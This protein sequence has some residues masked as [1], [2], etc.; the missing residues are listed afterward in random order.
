MVDIKFTEYL[1]RWTG[2]AKLHVVQPDSRHVL[3]EQSSVVTLQQWFSSASENN[4]VRVDWKLPLRGWEPDAWA[5]VQSALTLSGFSS[6]GLAWAS[7]YRDLF[8]DSLSESI[9]D[10]YLSA[11]FEGS[12]PSFSRLLDGYNAC[13]HSM[14]AGRHKSAT[15]RARL[16]VFRHGDKLG[17][18][19]VVFHLSAAFLLSV[20]QR[21]AFVIDHGSWG[22][23]LRG[24]LAP[25]SFEWDLDE[26]K[27]ILPDFDLLTAAHVGMDCSQL[28]DD[29]AEVLIFSVRSCMEIHQLAQ[30]PYF[31]K[32]RGFF[33]SR[34]A[35]SIVGLI[36]RLLFQPGALLQYDLSSRREGFAGK[37]LVG[38]AIRNGGFSVAD[39]MRLT[40]EDDEELIDVFSSC[41]GVLLQRASQQGKEAVVFVL[42]DSSD[43]MDRLRDKLGS[44]VHTPKHVPVHS[45]GDFSK[46]TEFHQTLL[47][48]FTLGEA[49]DAVI[50]HH[51]S[52]HV[53][54]Y[55]RTGRTAVSI[56]TLQ[57]MNWTLGI[58]P[59]SLAVRRAQLSDGRAKAL[60]L[61]AR[62]DICERREFYT[63]NW[64][65][66]PKKMNLI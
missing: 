14:I 40:W 23:D 13:H 19:N 21:R 25:P 36:S 34:S 43:T 11:T 16:L 46:S 39:V 35:A 47:D 56:N 54:A 53:T 32:L 37:E 57:F 15:Q 41:A 51:S 30:E 44:S 42:S 4:D 65:T 22:N 64:E 50:T 24:H 5:K 63:L 20:L 55:A 58:T 7:D 1:N 6:S 28:H 18:G 17:W 62:G 12:N 8:S 2:F 33:P 27:R 48:W 61:H 52:F 31:Q 29:S 60:K 9:C 66:D 38:V 45:I 49:S 26:V 59:R 3:P 10:T